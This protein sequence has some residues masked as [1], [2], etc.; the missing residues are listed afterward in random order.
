MDLETPSL[1]NLFDM[2]K[3]IFQ[4]TLPL[5]MKSQFLP[6]LEVRLSSESCINGFGSVKE[7]VHQL[8]GAMLE[9]GDY[10]QGQRIIVLLQET[11]SFIGHLQPVE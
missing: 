1:P 9:D 2:T 6:S 7:C 8:V 10:S 11:C 3:R 5:E 4:D